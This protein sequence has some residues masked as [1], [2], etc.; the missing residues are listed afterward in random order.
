MHNFERPV[1]FENC[2]TRWYKNLPVLKKETSFGDI[3]T[4]E[5]VLT[6]W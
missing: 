6:V 4:S 5:N 3:T 1:T 2:I